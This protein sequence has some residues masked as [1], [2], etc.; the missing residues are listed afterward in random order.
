FLLL[1]GA[2]LAFHG[3]MTWETLTQVK[4]PDLD[5]AGGALFSVA[6]IGAV[7]GLAVLL[8]LKVLFPESVPFRASVRDA[9]VDAWRFWSG[10]WAEALPVARNLRRRMHP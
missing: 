1:M 8:L 4:Q 10:V 9:G 5:A 2:A 6:L 7:N 3:L